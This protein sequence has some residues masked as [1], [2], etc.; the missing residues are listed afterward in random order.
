MDFSLER[1][2][3]VVTKEWNEELRPLRTES[4]SSTGMKWRV[5]T[6]ENRNEIDKIKSESSTG[7]PRTESSSARDLTSSRNF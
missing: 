1:S 4:E 2:I 5:E 6:I 3:Y 7:F